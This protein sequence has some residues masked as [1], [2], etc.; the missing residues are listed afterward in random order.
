MSDRDKEMIR[1]LRSTVQ[2]PPTARRDFLKMFGGGGS[3]GFSNFSGFGGRGR[4]PQRG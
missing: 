3:A 2:V 4:G 1:R